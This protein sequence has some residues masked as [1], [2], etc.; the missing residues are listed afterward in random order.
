MAS[1]VAATPG[2][3]V[4]SCR[5]KFDDARRRLLLFPNGNPAPKDNIALY[6]ECLTIGPVTAAQPCGQFALVISA[7]QQPKNYIVSHAFH[8]FVESEVDWGFTRFLLLSDFRQGRK[9]AD[10]TMLMPMLKKDSTVITVF[11]RVM[12]DP[13][14]FLWRSLTESDFTNIFLF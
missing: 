9:R 3:R 5:W 11:L 2:K 13:T 12:K 1:N 7:P 14:G 6:L 4:H 8:R 10:D